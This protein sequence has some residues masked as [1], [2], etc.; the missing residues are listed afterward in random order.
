MNPNPYVVIGFIIVVW[1]VMFFRILAAGSE[2]IEALQQFGVSVII[3]MLAVFLIF[4]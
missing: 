4:M 1:I 2:S 3:G